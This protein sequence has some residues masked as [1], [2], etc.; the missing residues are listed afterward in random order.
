L[1][2]WTWWRRCRAQNTSLTVAESSV[3]VAQQ[4]TDVAGLLVCGDHVEQ[5][6][7][8]EVRT[9][10]CGQLAAADHT[11]RPLK[12]HTGREKTTALKQLDAQLSPVAA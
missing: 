3:P 7:A 10:N 2:S 6:V 8:I 5:A 4:D 9:G 11:Y 12:S 1:T